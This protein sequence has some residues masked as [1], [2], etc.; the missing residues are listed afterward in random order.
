MPLYDKSGSV[1]RVEPAEDIVAVTPNDS[2][3]LPN[4]VCRALRCVS[5]GDVS[6]ITANGS[7]RTVTLY[8]QGEILPV[9]W[10]RIR[11]TGTT[12]DVEALY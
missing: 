10:N 7:S 4:G 8:Q 1:A 3:D 5:V 2:N 9:A 12:A 11:S 6:G